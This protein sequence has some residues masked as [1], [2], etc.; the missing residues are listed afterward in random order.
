MSSYE[1]HHFFLGHKEQK[2]YVSITTQKENC[3]ANSKNENKNVWI[4]EIK[5]KKVFGNHYSPSSVTF[6][7]L[8]FSISGKVKNL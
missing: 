8:S 2:I 3:V 1:A 6:P 5:K 7:F 4:F